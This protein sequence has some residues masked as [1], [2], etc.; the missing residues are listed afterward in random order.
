M[1]PTTDERLQMSDGNL[2]KMAYRKQSPLET[3]AFQ[4]G[5]F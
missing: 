3:L 1:K 2:K 5:F 4:A